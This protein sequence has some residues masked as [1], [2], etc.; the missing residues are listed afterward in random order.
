MNSL[1]EKYRRDL[2][3]D[4]AGQLTADQL[5]PIFRDINRLASSYCGRGAGRTVFYVNKSLVLKVPRHDGAISQNENEYQRYQ[6]QYLEFPMAPCRL[7]RDSGSLLMQRVKPV[8]LDANIPEWASKVDGG[9]VGR[10]N[11]KLVAFDYADRVP[12]PNS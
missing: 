12:Q 6:E 5:K 9:Q 11:G 8:A 4:Q 1:I 10:L 2:Y 3:T 7:I